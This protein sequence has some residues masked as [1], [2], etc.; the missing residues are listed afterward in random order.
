[1]AE[2]Y[3]KEECAKMIMR[4]RDLNPK[5]RIYIYN[6]T[7]RLRKLKGWG[8]K[9]IGRALG[10][11]FSTV[12]AWLY[13]GR[14]PPSYLY[15]M[16]SR[17]NLNPSPELS[18][19]TGALLGDGSWKRHTVMLGL[20][21]D[22]DFAEVFRDCIARIIGL[23]KI[24]NYGGYYR[25]G[26]PS[27]QLVNYLQNEDEIKGKISKFPAEFIRGFMDAEGCVI[28]HY[29]KRRDCF[30][31]YVECRNTNLGFI[32][33][34]QS[35]FLSIGFHPRVRKYK[36]GMGLKEIYV[37]NIGK[38]R[39]IIT[40]SKKIGFSIRRKQEKLEESIKVD[41]RAKETII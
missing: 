19:I 14:S 31:T 4:T 33:L 15:G 28:K 27:R 13:L 21:Q 37:L 24:N 5:K 36:R 34:A 6:K 9:K 18:Y 7:L 17:I 1:M 41:N 38:W 8:N 32:R 29:D 12:G 35:C 39:D 23:F 10:I 22:R 3:T 16:K 20:V 25:V 11:P 26:V 30:H 2:L 40:Y